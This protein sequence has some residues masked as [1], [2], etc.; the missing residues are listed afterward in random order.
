MSGD[1]G[2]GAQV[3]VRDASST[4]ASPWP[5]EP[6]GIIVRSGGSALAG[7]WGRGGGSR[8]WWIDFDEPQIN[9]EGD[10]PF[11]TAQVNEKYLELAPP[12]EFAP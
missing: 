6:T 5:G 4:D 10:G 2:I 11:A 1:F 12:V 9:A 8:I 7:V 3:S